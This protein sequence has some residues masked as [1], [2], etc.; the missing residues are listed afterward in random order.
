MKKKKKKHGV[1]GRS[2]E[3]LWVVVKESLILTGRV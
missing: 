1:K 2:K 3:S